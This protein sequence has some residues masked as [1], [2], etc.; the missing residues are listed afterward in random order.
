MGTAEAKTWDSIHSAKRTNCRDEK[1]RERPADAIESDQMDRLSLRIGERHRF[2]APV[3][4]GL[5][6]MP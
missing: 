2:V 5:D 3:G 1:T 6:R 4:T